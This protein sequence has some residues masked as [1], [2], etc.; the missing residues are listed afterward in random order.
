MPFTEMLIGAM[1]ALRVGVPWDLATD[2]G[3]II[4]AQARDNIVDHI[5]KALQNNAVL[6][7]L[8][9]PSEGYFIAP[10]LIK[11]TGIKALGLE[12]FGT[13]LNIATYRAEDLD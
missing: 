7:D 1:Q 13:V 6:A 12:V 4:D 8:N 9:V 2:V 5:E 3:P 11:V 10:T